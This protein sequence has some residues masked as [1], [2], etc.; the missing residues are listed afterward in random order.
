M[1]KKYFK[2]FDD[3]HIENNVV[4]FNGETNVDI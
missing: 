3:G 1:G 2:F 4:R